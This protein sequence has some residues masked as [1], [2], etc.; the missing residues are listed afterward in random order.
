VRQAAKFLSNGT[1]VFLSWSLLHGD[2]MAPAHTER[3]PLWLYVFGWKG[4]SL[5]VYF[6]T[7]QRPYTFA[8]TLLVADGTKYYRQ[9]L[10][11]PR[12]IPMPWVRKRGWR[13]PVGASAQAVACQRYC[14]MPRPSMRRK[15]STLSVTI[16]MPNRRLVQPIQRSFVPIS[17]PRRRSSR[18]TLA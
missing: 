4:P 2:R 17:S 13:N 18:T 12:P 15:C 9:L 5:R 3:I 7:A 14:T 6:D 11:W 8:M 10:S 1:C 16:G